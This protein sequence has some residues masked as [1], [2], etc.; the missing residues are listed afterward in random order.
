MQDSCTTLLPVLGRERLTTSAGILPG[1]ARASVIA[2][3]AGHP[4]APRCATR[5]PGSSAC[6]RRS[7]PAPAKGLPLTGNVACSNSGHRR[8]QREFESSILNYR[9]W[10]VAIEA[11]VKK[12][13]A[14]VKSM[15]TSIVAIGASM[16]A[17]ERS[18][19]RIH[20]PMSRS[21]PF[22]AGDG[23]MTAELRALGKKVSAPGRQG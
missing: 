3:R 17:M 14:P 2:A 13:H 10:I 20:L 12:I 23:T 11:W 7:P 8:S 6:G 19:I 16:T 9:P 21:G 15:Q 4:G 18:M 1:K 22:A 5:P